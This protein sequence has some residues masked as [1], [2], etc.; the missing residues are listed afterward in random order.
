MGSNAERS[1]VEKQRGP[2]ALRCL[3]NTTTIT[4]HKCFRVVSRGGGVRHLRRR[5]QKSRYAHIASPKLNFFD[6]R[7]QRLP[8]NAHSRRLTWMPAPL[9][10]PDEPGKRAARRRSRSAFSSFDGPATSAPSTRHLRLALHGRRPLRGFC[11][12]KHLR[13]LHHL[14]LRTPT[15]H[16]EADGPSRRR[17]TTQKSTEHQEVDGSLRRSSPRGIHRARVA[18][19]ADDVQKRCM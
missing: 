7:Y 16:P 6:A 12:G 1:A 18:H 2:T 19:E 14:L 17:Q 11:K 10:R 9:A 8:A 13:P 15:D 5:R 3:Q 4:K